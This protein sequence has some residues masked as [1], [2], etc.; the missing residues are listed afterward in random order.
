MHKE[1]LKLIWKGIKNSFIAYIVCLIV[2]L[3]AL[4]TIILAP[5]AV[6]ALIS[7]HEMLIADGK[8]DYRKLLTQIDDDKNYFKTLLVILVES[9]TVM[10]GFALFVVPGVILALAL[11]PVNYL[12]YKGKAPKI[13]VLIP[14]SMDLMRGKKTKLFLVLLVLFGAYTIVYAL[15]GIVM[16]LLMQVSV[17][18]AVPIVIILVA[19]SLFAVMDFFTL[20]VMFLRGLTEAAE[21]PVITA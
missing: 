7:M 8:I 14:A 17:V 10:T 4:S 5:F 1:S 11:M 20:T 6:R 21:Q 19:L 16:F 12:L 3:V 9:V 13:S 15:F 2:S 18:L